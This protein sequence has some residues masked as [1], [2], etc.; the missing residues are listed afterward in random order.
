MLYSTVIVKVTIMKDVF[1]LGPYF[2]LVR[3]IQAPDP[4]LAGPYEVV[5]LD[6][7]WFDSHVDRYA[8]L[9]KLQPSPAVTKAVGVGARRGPIS[10][11]ND[12]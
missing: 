6:Q 9:R 2:Q 1:S 12:I 5:M 8:K 10:T 11:P 7:K 4:E 3:M